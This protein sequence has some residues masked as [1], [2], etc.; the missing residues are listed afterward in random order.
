MNGAYTRLVSG[1][2]TKLKLNSEKTEFLAISS[3][4]HADKVVVQQLQLTDTS[5]QRSNYAKNLGVIMVSRMDM[6]KHISEICRKCYYY[7]RWNWCIRK[8]LT[9]ETL[10]HALVISR[11]DYANGI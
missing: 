2:L 4:Y 8:F 10:I 5:V 1:C 3:L 6:Q 7:I 11:L 9:A